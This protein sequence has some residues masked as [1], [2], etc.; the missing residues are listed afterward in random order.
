MGFGCSPFRP[1][2]ARVD[3]QGAVRSALAAG[4]RLFDLAELYGNERAVGCELRS[5]AAPAR[6]D[7]II[8]GKVWRTNFRPAALR[9]ACEDSL[10]R[11]GVEA[12]D[13]YLLHAPEAWR[14]RGPLGDPE[15][16]G[17]EELERR[18]YPRDAE[19]RIEA[20]AVPLAETWGAMRDLVRRGLAQW[21]GVSNFAAD[22]LEALGPELPA[23]NQIACSPYRPN[24]TT[25]E[26]CRR[27]GIRLLTHSP[28]SAAGL[29]SDS[30]LL[31]LA[32]GSGLTPAQIVLRWN[33]Q[34]GLLPLPSSANPDHIRENLNA[35]DLPLDE[36]AMA[37]VDSLGDP[38]ALDSL[39]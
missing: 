24:A 34:K 10:R 16:V 13:L 28:L 30:R 15:A 2:G 29:L 21:I 25:V 17:W 18:V 31:A 35:L 12:F 38:G 19:G 6:G 9:Q 39:S 7:L 23:A 37:A 5:P 22:H 36:A 8:I 3:L 1:G 27:R 33:L 14:H 4:Y 32:R 11:L 26:A 20:D